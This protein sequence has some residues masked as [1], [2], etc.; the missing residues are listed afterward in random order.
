M[1]TI[2]HYDNHNWERESVS[3]LALSSIKGIG[4]WTLFKLASIGINFNSVIK[5]DSFDEFKEYFAK[6]GC[7]VP[8]KPDTEWQEYQKLVWREGNELYKR[9]KQLGARIIH[10]NEPDFPDSLRNIQEPPRWLFVQGDISVLK[11]PKITIV[12]T[13][14]PSEDGIILANYVGSCIPFFNAATVSGLA[15]GIDQIIHNM[16]IRFEVPTIAVLGNGVLVNYPAGSEQLREDV[17]AYGGVVLTEYLPEQSYSAE[18]F[19]RRNRIQAGLGNVLVPV[20][21][22]ARSGTSHTVRYASAGNKP[23]FC[24]RMPDWLDKDHNELNLARELGGKD[25]I[26]PI[27]SNQ[28]I[29]DIYYGI[30]KNSISKIQSESRKDY[31]EKKLQKHE[32]MPYKNK[33]IA[34]SEEERQLDIWA[35]I[36]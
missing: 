35:D 32:E 25:Y 16:S 3:L 20:E 26:Y 1:D 11:R 12:G 29:E 24:L 2:T 7:R 13:R 33:P 15:T 8:N 5:A 17:A 9:V 36:N 4:Y 14:K 22:K 28:F 23:I 21:W 18:N 10:F 30:H 19:V 6:A 27:E 31:Q 34:T